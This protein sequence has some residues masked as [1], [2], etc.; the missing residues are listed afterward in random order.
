[1]LGLA[2][3]KRIGL[4]EAKERTAIEAGALKRGPYKKRNQKG[5]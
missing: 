2:S 3:K 5:D 4:L 1:M